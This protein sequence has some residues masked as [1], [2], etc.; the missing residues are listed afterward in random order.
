M[1]KIFIAISLMLASTMSVMANTTKQKGDMQMFEAIKLPYETTIFEPSISQKTFEFHYGKHYKTYLD[2]LNKL[3]DGNAALSGKNVVE[4][5]KIAHDKP[6]LA[7]LFN[8]AAQVYNHEFYF[9]NLKPISASLKEQIKYEF[10]SL[11]KFMQEWK[12]QS[13]AQFGSGWVWLVENK[14]G[15]LEI[16]KTSNAQTPIAE[17]IAPLMTIDVWEHAYYIDYQNRR[18]DYID[19]YLDIVLK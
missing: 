12:A 13:L 9:N 19:A 15:K 10:G 2:N 6:E 14:E 7:G 18:G 4:I 16:V 3:V 5:I 17:D 11:E 8:N 1:N